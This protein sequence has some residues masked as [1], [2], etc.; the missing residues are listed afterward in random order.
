MTLGPSASRSQFAGLDVQVDKA[1]LFSVS[2]EDL[3]LGK[4]SVNPGYRG[5][6]IFCVYVPWTAMV[7]VICVT[8]LNEVGLLLIDM[9]IPQSHHISKNVVL[10]PIDASTSPHPIQF[11]SQDFH[12]CSCVHQNQGLMTSIS[13]F[14]YLESLL[15]FLFCSM[16]VY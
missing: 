12:L 10:C 14:D 4:V 5:I 15:H 13:C 3:N 2:D 9:P 8:C 16:H 6:V 11:H 1:V 7:F